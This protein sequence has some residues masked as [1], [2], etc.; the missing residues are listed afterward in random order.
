MLP[1]GGDMPFSV[2]GKEVLDSL[3]IKIPIEH[4]S[5]LISNVR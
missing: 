5:T 3:T 4:F 2:P 1:I